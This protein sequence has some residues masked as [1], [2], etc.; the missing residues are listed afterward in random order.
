[1]CVFYVKI[2]SCFIPLVKDKKIRNAPFHLAPDFH[3]HGVIRLAACP[4]R[5]FAPSVRVNSVNGVAPKRR[6]TIELP[7]RRVGGGGIEPSTNGS[8]SM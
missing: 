3:G 8:K 6:S 5:I 2:V 1:M 7:A 4:L